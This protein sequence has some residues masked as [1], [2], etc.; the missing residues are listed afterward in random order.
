V[1][2]HE[3]TVTRFH[4][5]QWRRRLVA[6]RPYL[7]AVLGAGLLG[8]LGWVVLFS[9]WLAVE[10]TEV[11]GL[12]RL[13]PKEVLAVADIEVGTPMAR[14]DLD[15]VGER[16]AAVPAVADV[17]VHRSWPHTVEIAVTERQPLATLQRDGAWWVMDR[18]GVVFR[19][20]AHRHKSLP[21]V[22]TEGEPRP[23]ALEEVAAVVAV[24]PDSLQHRVDR[25]EVR[26]MDAIRLVLSDGREVVWGSAAESD[27]KLEVLDALLRLPAKVYDVSVPGQPTTSG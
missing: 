1:T 21:V 3:D 26:S 6:V 23:D 15:E 2:P 16:I 19:K 25:L 8:F 10:T 9:S 5:R 4:R 12:E 17:S 20:T 13:T 27:R 14:L 11:S 24:L 18:E 7:L 22:E